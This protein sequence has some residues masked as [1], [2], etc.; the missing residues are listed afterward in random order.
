MGPSSSR[1]RSRLKH[2]PLEN[3]IAATGPLRSRSKKRKARPENE[4]SGYVDSRASRKIL[5]IGQDQATEEQENK[6]AVAPNPAFTFESRVEVES[7]PEGDGGDDE[8]AW[9]DEEEDVVEEVVRI[10]DMDT[11]RQ[12]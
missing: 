8:E 5:K 4:E 3:D 2:Q 10:F 9:G 11:S 6:E 1:S 7:E 12:G